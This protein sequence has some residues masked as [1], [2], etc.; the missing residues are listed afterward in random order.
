[1]AKGESKFEKDLEGL[2]Q[3]IQVIRVRLHE[4]GTKAKNLESLL[5]AA[6]QAEEKFKQKHKSKKHHTS[7]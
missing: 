6:I 4:F 5:H 1:M 7:E 3:R 2:D